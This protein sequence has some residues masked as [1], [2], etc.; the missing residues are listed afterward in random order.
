MNIE[1][2]EALALD[3]PDA[4]SLAQLAELSGLPESMLRELVEYDALAPIDPRAPAWSFRSRTLITA[5]T[6]CRLHR[7]FELDAFGVSVLLRYVE[8]IELLEAEV[9]TLRARR[10]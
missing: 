8:R 10:T 6:A 1:M 9:R 2:A 5:R 7:D 4:L 3:G